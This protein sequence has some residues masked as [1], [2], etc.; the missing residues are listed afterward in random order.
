MEL[1]TPVIVTINYTDLGL[2]GYK[3]S[4]ST[5]EKLKS[6]GSGGSIFARRKLKRIDGITPQ[7]VDHAA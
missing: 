3:N 4:I 2:V 1:D 5:I 7:V 6:L